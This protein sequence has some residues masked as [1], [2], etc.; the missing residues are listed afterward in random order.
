MK[1]TIKFYNKERGFG[2][3]MHNN[4]DIFFHVSG[5]IDK[6][7]EQGDLVEFLITEGRKGVQAVNVERI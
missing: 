1:G 4:K 3:I 5:L 2:F 7:I 6:D